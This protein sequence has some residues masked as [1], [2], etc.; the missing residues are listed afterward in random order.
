MN[1]VIVLSALILSA[2]VA[3][4]PVIPV[5]TGSVVPGGTVTRGGTT[6]LNLL[7]EPLQ[8]GDPLPSVALVDTNLNSVDLSSRRGEVLLLSVVP[9]LDTQVCERQTHILGEAGT[10]LSPDIRRVTISRDLPFAQKRFADET[11]FKDIL[12]L[13]DYQQAEFGRA[14]GL[15]VDQIY[16]LARSVLVVDQEGKV[17][18]LQVVP[19]LSHLPDMTA[20]LAAAEAL[21]KGE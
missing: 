15:L 7:G 14:T 19:E 11:G 18:Y 12:F 17:R 4:V 10:K 6:V 5:A 8:V 13:S 2:C 20:A 21:L 9:S 16:L 1:L 3:H